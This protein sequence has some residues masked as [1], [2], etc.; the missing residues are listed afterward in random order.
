MLNSKEFAKALEQKYSQKSPKSSVRNIKVEVIDK[1]A[2]ERKKLN[3]DKEDL[4]K[5]EFLRS[6]KAKSGIPDAIRQQTLIKLRKKM[7]KSA[8]KE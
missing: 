7:K 1:E 4:Q 6:K 5:M 3:S 8:D 2:E